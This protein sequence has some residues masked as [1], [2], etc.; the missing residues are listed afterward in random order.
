M[1][2]LDGPEAA[3]A[4]SKQMAKARVERASSTIRKPQVDEVASGRRMS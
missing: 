4:M 3:G 1:R 2:S